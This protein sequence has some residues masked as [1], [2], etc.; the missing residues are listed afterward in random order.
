MPAGDISPLP[1]E[2]KQFLPKQAQE[3]YVDVYNRE[4]REYTSPYQRKGD[5]D[6]LTT[7]KKAAWAAVLRLYEKNSDG[8]WQKKVSS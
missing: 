4:W 8:R 7:A 2:F 3:L 6:H 1:D 5:N